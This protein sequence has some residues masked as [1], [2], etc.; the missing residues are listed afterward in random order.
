[1]VFLVCCEV[2]FLAS[3][4]DCYDSGGFGT[5]VGP[6]CALLRQL[7]LILLFGVAS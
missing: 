3:D 1:M 5:G 4:H 2:R 6:G 7:S